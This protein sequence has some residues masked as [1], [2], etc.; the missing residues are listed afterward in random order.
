MTPRLRTPRLVLRPPAADDVEAVFALYSD[1][2]A[3]RHWSHPPWRSRAQA[4]AYLG[5]MRAAAARGTVAVW[6][7]EEGARAVGVATLWFLGDGRNAEVGY[8]LGRAHWGRG[9]ASELL[10]AVL[11]DGFG[12]RRLRHVDADVAAGNLRSLRLLARLGFVPWAAR[13][14]IA[15]DGSPVPGRVLRLEADA[16]AAPP[17]A[18]APL[19]GV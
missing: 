18:A 15:H 10:E 12:R 3:M 4:E 6:L 9:L 2:E 5:T 14:R 16:F 8:L 19:G 17:R 1:P 13:T 11:A 7:A